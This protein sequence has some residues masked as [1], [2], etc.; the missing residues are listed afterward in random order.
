MTDFIDAQV[1]R[2]MGDTN[3]DVE[4]FEA[5]ADP[6]ALVA[7]AALIERVPVIADPDAPAFPPIQVP[8]KRGQWIMSDEVIDAWETRTTCR[9]AIQALLAVRAQIKDPAAC[10]AIWHYTERAWARYAALVEQNG[11]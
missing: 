3:L 4:L 7:G 11:A 5:Q 10:E 8:T 6:D 1:A 2:I 9:S